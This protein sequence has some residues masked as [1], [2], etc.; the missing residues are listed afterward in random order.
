M[1]RLGPGATQD[2]AWLCLTEVMLTGNLGLVTEVTSPCQRS[3][4]GLSPDALEVLVLMTL[5]VLAVTL[6]G[7]ETEFD[8]NIDPSGIVKND[9]SPQLAF[10]SEWEEIILFLLLLFIVISLNI[11]K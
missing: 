11:L 10:A 7:P 4:N 9:S 2:E 5:R 6:A 1:L 3:V 8:P